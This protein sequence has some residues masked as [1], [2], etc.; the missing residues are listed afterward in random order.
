MAISITEVLEKLSK[1]R[2]EPK[3]V[4]EILKAA[5]QAA[6][7]ARQELSKKVREFWASDE[8]QLVKYMLEW[9]AEQS[10]F[11]AEME[12][13]MEGVKDEIKKVA[14]AVGLGNRY[15][16]VWGKPPKPSS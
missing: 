14:K 5:R 8:G 4:E 16:M 10:G 3:D 15:R 2:V 7:K 12:R 13:I 11:A 9:E 6:I 1:E